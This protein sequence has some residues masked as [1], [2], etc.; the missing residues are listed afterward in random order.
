MTRPREF[1]CLLQVGGFIYD[2]GGSTDG[3]NGSIWDPLIKSD[4][5][6]DI[7]EKG[8]LIPI[9]GP[10]LLKA[11]RVFTAVNANGVIYTVS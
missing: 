9:Q 10:R 3:L 7:F 11:R 8:S 5:F 1:S 2:I 6:V 4:S